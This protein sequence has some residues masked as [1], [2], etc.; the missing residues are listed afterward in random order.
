MARL[1]APIYA[2]LGTSM[3]LGDY[4]RVVRTFLEAFKAE[5]ARPT[6]TSPV[7]AT[8]DANGTGNEN[9]RISETQGE[10]ANGSG[11]RSPADEAQDE[12]DWATLKE[13]LKVCML[14]FLRFN[15]S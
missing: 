11:S 12:E 7:R 13:D 2:P 9:G 4:V 14:L 6:S 15:Q 5:G 3:G 8:G 1:A 10:E